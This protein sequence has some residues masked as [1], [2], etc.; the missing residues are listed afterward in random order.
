M[1]DEPAG[2]RAHHAAVADQAHGGGAQ[3]HPRCAA[4]AAP[5]RVP[6]SATSTTGAQHVAGHPAEAARHEAGR[7]QRQ[8]PRHRREGHARDP[9]QPRGQRAG[10]DRVDRDPPSATGPRRTRRRAPAP[11][12]RAP[13]RRPR[14][15]APPGRSPGPARGRGG[16][17]GATSA[18]SA[19]TARRQSRMSPTA[20]NTPMRLSRMMASRRAASR[21][22][23]PSRQ[24]ASPSR[25]IPPVATF[26]PVTRS[27]AATSGGN[28]ASAASAATASAP[29]SSSPTTGNHHAARPSADGPADSAAGHRGDGEKAERQDQRAHARAAADTPLRRAGPDCAAG[30]TRAAWTR[31]SPAA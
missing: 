22:A 31:R 27:A 16:G 13:A 28:S 9:E 26:H 4:A 23:R 25:W 14:A 10:H 1:S 30:G 3:S 5:S 8:T 29:P 7:E 11:A 17:A 6:S 19:V 18:A 24:S 15:A 21:P 20:P 12:W 2:L